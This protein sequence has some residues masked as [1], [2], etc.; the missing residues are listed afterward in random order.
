MFKGMIKCNILLILNTVKMPLLTNLY[1]KDICSSELLHEYR[2]S[3]EIFVINNFL[4]NRKYKCIYIHDIKQRQDNSKLKFVFSTS[5]YQL[6][7][8]NSCKI[9]YLFTKD[10]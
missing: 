9:F 5:K 7:C 6:F 4:E 1:S 10:N 2:T 8:L 3:T